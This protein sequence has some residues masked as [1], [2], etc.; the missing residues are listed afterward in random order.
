MADVS[1]ATLAGLLVDLREP[2]EGIHEDGTEEL[3]SWDTLW[4]Q[5]QKAA[6]ELERLAPSADKSS[7]AGIIDPVVVPRAWIEAA[8]CPECDGSGFNVRQ[9]AAGQFEQVQC[10]WCDVRHHAMTSV[11]QSATAAT[12]GR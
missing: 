6:D 8:K 11:A 2:R 5:C 9:Y 3:K 7:T 1:T 4:D 10:E 12:Q